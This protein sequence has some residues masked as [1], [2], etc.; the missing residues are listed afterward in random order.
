M[1][2]TFELTDAA[3]AGA[4]VTAWAAGAVYNLTVGPYATTEPTNAWIH[5]SAGTLAPA[6]AAMHASAAACDA[7]VFSLMP[8]PGS[9]AATWTAPTDDTVGVTVS[10]AQA[11]SPASGF[12]VGLVCS[13]RS[14]RVLQCWIALQHL[15]GCHPELR[16][17]RTRNCS[18]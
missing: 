11:N 7:A 5:A 16:P 6:D 17:T 12:A 14:A 18:M 4:A 13:S 10:T 9:H 8:V 3:G 1:Q 15:Q 2:I